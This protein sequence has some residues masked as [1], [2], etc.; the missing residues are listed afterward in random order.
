MADCPIS[1]AAGLGIILALVFHPARA[2]TD[3][4][5]MGRA[6]LANQRQ[7][8]AGAIAIYQDL[9]R[10]GRPSGPLGLG[11]MLWAGIGAPADHVRACDQFARA[12]QSG[13]PTATE[14]LADCFHNG[15][16]RLR[17]YARSAQLYAEAEQRGVP[18]AACAL[19]QQYLLAQGFPAN[20]ARAATLCRRSAERGEAAAAVDLGQM[21]LTGT[22]LKRDPVEASQWFAKAAAQ[23][24]PTAALLLGKLYWTG[25]G[26]AKD[27][28]HAAAL[29]RQAALHKQPSAPALLADYYMTTALLP[30]SPSTGPQLQVEPAIKAAFWAT[31][32]TRSDPNPATR[33]RAQ[34][35]VD[36]L[37]GVA[38]GLQDPV[39]TLLAERKFP[40]E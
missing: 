12:E 19:G 10:R 20:P 15:D 8:F 23:G 29:W 30:A 31:V 33:T 38:S 28:P 25:D 4:E 24:Q 40:A 5:A 36:Q 26:V 3:E 2:E 6:R 14:L 32:A 18:I 17:D 34:Q 1:R 21:Y 13:N 35:L 27:R 39:A 22:G 11:L 9:D 16:G 37:Y 7:D